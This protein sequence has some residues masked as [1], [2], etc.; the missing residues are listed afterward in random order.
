MES[1]QAQTLEDIEIICVN[2]GS[3][4]GSR[5]VLEAWAARDARICVV[6][7]QNGG[8]SSA[9]NAGIHA[10]RSPY[11]CF[12]S[13]RTTAFTRGRARRWSAY[14][15]TRGRMSSTFGS[16]WTPKD[17][18]YPWLEWALSPRDA[19]FDAFDPDLPVQG[20]LRPFA[21][22][23]ACRTGFLLGNDLFFDETVKFGEG[24]EVWHL[25]STLD[26]KKRS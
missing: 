2:D 8:L 26:R 10:A 5:S 21:W 20:G 3:T 9:R 14:L 16:T 15:R 12:S 24:Q 4:D 19:E 22:R 18:G 6:D 13:I 11:V 25:P 7:K 23:T 1:L 17:E